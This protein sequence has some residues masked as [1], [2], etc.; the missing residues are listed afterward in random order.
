MKN[1]AMADEGRAVVA[2]A[3]SSGSSGSISS[4]SD[5]SW[6]MSKSTLTSLPDRA[7]YPWPVH[8]CGCSSVSQNA[9]NQ[10]YRCIARLS[11]PL[12]SRSRSIATVNVAAQI[13]ERFRQP[14]RCAGFE[15]LA[16]E[17]HATI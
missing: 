12:P 7:R 8:S 10:R 15:L 4:A 2:D 11:L 6:S 16:R 9:A 13:F 1:C 3:A 14:G 5:G 17:V